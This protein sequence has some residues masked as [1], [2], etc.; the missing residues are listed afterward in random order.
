MESAPLMSA[1]SVSGRLFERSAAHGPIGRS[2]VRESLRLRDW[3]NACCPSTLLLAALAVMILALFRL[4]LFEGWTFIGDSDR[5]NTVLNVRLFEVNQIQSRGSVSTWSDGQFMGSSMTGLHWMLPGFTP[6]PYLLALFPVTDTFWLLGVFAALLL[7]LSIVSA[8]VTIR[9]YTPSAIAAAAGAM[10]YG[11][12]AYVILRITQLDVS[13]GLLIVVPLMLKVIRETRREN[14]AR[15][16]LWLTIAWAAL[17]LLTFLQEVAYVSFLVGSYA[18]YRSARMRTLWPLL[19]LG[20]AFTIGT[21]IGLPRVITVGQ[22]FGELW[23]SST[24]LQTEP[25]QAFRFF[26]DGILG[27]YHGEQDGPLKGNINLHEGIQMLGSALA[28]LAAISAGLMSRSW[29]MR[30]LGVAL[31]VVLGVGYVDYNRAFYD[32]GFGKAA[33]PSPELRSLF[34]NADLIGLPLWLISGR[35]VRWASRRRTTLGDRESRALLDDT[36]A[37]SVDAPFFLGLVVVVLA[38]ILIPE[39]HL[40]LYYAFFKIDFTHSRLSIDALLPLAALTAIFFGRFLPERLPI[41]ALRWVAIGLSLGVLLWLFREQEAKVVV[42]SAGSVWDVRPD[43][44]VTIEAVRIAT[45]FLVLAGAIAVLVSRP[46]RAVLSIAGGVLVGWMVLENYVSADFVLNGPQT[47]SQ[48]IPF[49]S[50]NHLNAAPGELRPPTAE[51]RAPVRARLEAD[52][53]RTILY[54]DKNRFPALVEPHLSAFWDLRLLEGYSTGL[55]RR[56]GMLPFAASMYSP[57]NLDIYSTNAIK[58]LPWQFLARLNV[59]YLVFVDRPLWFNPGPGA[60]DPQVDAQTLRVLENPFPVTPR[61]FFAEQVTPA[62][63]EPLFPGDDGVRP[64]LKFP[65]TDNPEEH[66]VAEGL[67]QAQQFSTE[68]TPAAT[69]DGDHVVVKVTPADQPR[70]LVLNELYHPAWQA[71]VDGQPA[72]IYPTNVVMRGI[73]VPPGA[74]TVELRFVPFLISPYGLLIFA[75]GFLMAG[76]C[77]WGV[78][79]LTRPGEPRPVRVATMVPRV[80]TPSVHQQVGAQDLVGAG[81]SDFIGPR[82]P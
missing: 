18:L 39:A 58:D 13:F 42:A 79:R 5:L 15:S 47:L 77:W 72:T 38:L 44:M 51:E 40:A 57:H 34:L 55:P 61:V 54:Q 65:E 33:Y 22:D 1:S 2:F 63:P 29:V 20:F 19:I 12:S 49:D 10:A 7:G 3:A 26:G 24:N 71:T 14:A 25:V 81:R 9:V 82:Q 80:V 28:A 35:L 11:L 66:S 48:A 37:A 43:R 70:F 68:G 62:G 45:S 59:K 76:L 21:V 52:D 74:T 75:V 36:P 8:Y 56:L 53:Y 30:L 17:F 69:F 50:F 31:V 23:R 4:S 67:P 46:P 41:S 32:L 64:A 6:L 60:A 78:R 73:V 16:F 27:R